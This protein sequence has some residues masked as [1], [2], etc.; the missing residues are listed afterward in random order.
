MDYIKE[1]KR[2]VAVEQYR[3]Y[4]Q[5]LINDLGISRSDFN[6]KRAFYDRQGR[7]VV[8][9][10]ESEFI[11]ENGYYIELTKGSN[12]EPLNKERTVYRIP[13]NPHYDQEYELGERSSYLVPVEELRP[14]NKRSVAISGS[15][16]VINTPGSASAPSTRILAGSTEVTQL[17]GTPA[18]PR[19]FSTGDMGINTQTTSEMED[20]PYSAMTIRDYYAMMSGKPVSNKAWLNQLIKSK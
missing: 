10:F 8:G 4:H 7:L 18:T 2:A 11:R 5:D 19:F 13:H 17:S 1:D 14:V 20:A 9:I 3:N 15:S 6:I 12:H 16:A